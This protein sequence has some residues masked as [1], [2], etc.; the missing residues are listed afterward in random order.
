MVAAMALNEV[1]QYP[2]SLKAIQRIDQEYRPAYTWLSK[3][4][5]AKGGRA[6]LYPLAI[7]QLNGGPEAEA[8]P[9]KIAGQWLK[10]SAFTSLQG[11]VNQLYS[12]QELAEKFAQSLTELREELA[13]EFDEEDQQFQAGDAK[14]QAAQQAWE[15]AQNAFE[16]QSSQRQIDLVAQINR[17]LEARS[18][19]MLRTLGEV[20][21]NSRMIKIEIYNGAS[22]DMIF[23][24]A[25]PKYKEVAK[26]LDSELKAEKKKPAG[27]VWEW[28][29][30]KSSSSK[31]EIWE[32]E[33]GAFKADVV[34]NCSNKNKYLAL[35][36]SLQAL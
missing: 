24:N 30:V 17:D 31:V 1:C 9:Q 32:D 28:G 33:L 25:H 20:A 14:L 15:A 6:E 26:K 4:S 2:D 5:R 16:S 3:W 36:K 34:D 13:D 10:S 27:Q 23:Q 12:E 8:V 35:R 21:E 22:H 11:E 7:A 19:S 29:S 18:L